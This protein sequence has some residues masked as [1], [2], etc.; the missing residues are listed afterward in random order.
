MKLRVGITL[1]VV[2]IDKAVQLDLPSRRRA[3][4][5]NPQAIDR[6][7]SS[8]VRDKNPAGKDEKKKKKK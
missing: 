6:D 5:A 3:R 1:A 7:V 8:I 4:M 2:F